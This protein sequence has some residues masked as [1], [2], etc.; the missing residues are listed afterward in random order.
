GIFS[1][2]ER[3]DH[4]KAMLERVADDMETRQSEQEQAARAKGE[5]KRPAGES[6][7][8]KHGAGRMMAGVDALHVATEFRSL[9]QSVVALWCQDERTEGHRSIDTVIRFDQAVDQA[10]SDSLESFSREKKSQ[11]R[12][13]E[14]M[15]L[16]LP[17]PSYVVDLEGY[18]LYANR[19]M[20]ELCGIP[21]SDLIGKQVTELHTAMAE[22]IHHQSRKVLEEASHI[23]A[24]TS[25]EDVSGVLRHYECIHAPVLDEQERIEAIV[26]TARDITERHASE[27]DIWHYANHDP[28][29]GLPNRRLFGD[30]L[31]QHT[32]HADRTTASLALL[33][34]DLDN[35]K[36]VNDRLGH[37][38]GDLL[39]QQA[40]DRI[41]ACVRESDTVARLGGDEFTVILLD[42]DDLDQIDKI[43]RDILD[44]IAR[45]FEL[46]DDT[47]SV[48]A[49][50][51]TTL[52]PRDA[53]T[54][55]Q[56]VK[57]ADQAMY[58]AK[59]GGRN[60]RR[61]FAELAGPGGSV[62]LARE[63]RNVIAQQQL[64]LYYQPIMD[65]KHNRIA[66]AEAL[67][68]WAH[69][70]RGLL[71][72]SSFVQLAEET[73]LMRDIERWVL[74]EAGEF[75]RSLERPPGP[76]FQIMLNRSAIQ[77]CHRRHEDE[78]N[79]QLEGLDLGEG[80]LAIEVTEQVF[81]Q[82]QQ[83]LEQNLV[84]LREAGMELALDDYGTGQSS[85]DALTRFDFS[86]L[87]IAPTFVQA[88]GHSGSGQAIAEAIIAMAHQLGLKV[89]A[90]GVETRA[91]KDWLAANGCDYAQGFFF[92]ESLPADAFQ[93]LIQKEST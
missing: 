44:E 51:G 5:G 92:S 28:L 50:I 67:L 85:M 84:K 11:Q 20:T 31:K 64:R 63:L 43:A 37:E 39:L 13:L 83:C 81:S 16:S 72:P 79:A 18:F 22:N 3:R 30:R 17:D 88:Y 4:A 59:A 77:F 89:I 53:G 1:R 6:A 60:Q 73:G 78:W 55:Q 93:A 90:E 40:A 41:C 54:Y 65:L 32:S 14:T 75:Y 36:E 70:S 29:T 12:L 25:M 47:G 76:D 82:N 68:R 91:Q 57:N 27:A 23:R 10:L 9:R 86:Y 52:Y 46:G 33:F 62:S 58:A 19:A 80:G 7:A 2:K 49:S 35:F 69:P 66:K 42:I 38:A 21:L 56:L 45:P 61:H 48:S 26:G 34:I 71:L 24:E 87:K 8:Q 74:D 15:V